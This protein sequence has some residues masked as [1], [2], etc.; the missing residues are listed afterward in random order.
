MV[1]IMIRSQLY[2][3][4]NNK[5]MV[6]KSSDMDEDMIIFDL[7]DSVPDS[8]K[9]SAREFILEFIQNST[10]RK[11]IAIRI[12]AMDTGYFYHDIIAID[13]AE[14]KPDYLVV[15]KSELGLSHI[16]RHLGIPVIALIETARGM[17]KLDDVISQEGIEM[18]SWAAGDL[19]FS[20]GGNIQGYSSNLY[21][22]TKVAISSRSFGVKAMDK[23]YFDLNNSDGFAEECRE[24]KS[25]GYEGKQVIHPSQVA[26]ANQIFS[27]TREEI[28]WA[29]KIIRAYRESSSM[30]KGALNVDG[31]LVD[32]VHIRMAES[33]IKNSGENP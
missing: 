2:V 15:P 24:A 19:S 17:N 4:S 7:E 6:N 32:S 25:L 27:P 14:K 13:R 21:L 1:I 22:K 28:E 18:V 3:P 26:I 9:D 10:A 31:Q 8:E 11:K 29:K 16:Y 20:A 33:I 30:G 5:K 12:N 23:V